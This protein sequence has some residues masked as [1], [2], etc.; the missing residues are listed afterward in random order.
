MKVK[1]ESEVFQ[2]CPPL[3]D[4][5]DCSL[6]GSSVHG[7]FQARVLE[8]GAIAFSTIYIYR[9]EIIY[10]QIR[11]PIN[12]LWEEL[13][14]YIHLSLQ[15]PN[16]TITYTKMNN[17]L[18]FISAN[19]TYFTCKILLALLQCIFNHIHY[20]IMYLGYI[21]QDKSFFLWLSGG[22]KQKIKTI[23]KAKNSWLTYFCHQGW[24]LHVFNIG[25][26]WSN[27]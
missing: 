15:S 26:K 9:S 18:L 7:I 4:P 2:S 6:P 1:S 22:M 8:W 25:N 14:N 21:N 3:S 16:S 20:A 27:H 17:L 13:L 19:Y 23:R 11:Q 5:M 10:W 24:K 12:E